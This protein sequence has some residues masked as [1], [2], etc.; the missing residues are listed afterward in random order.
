MKA[1]DIQVYNLVTQQDAATSTT[2]AREATA[3]G[4]S[5]KV[6][7]V[8]T[9]TFLPGTFLSSVFGMSMLNT[10]KWWLYVAI[11]LPLTALV[12]FIWWAW[13]KFPK[14]AALSRHWTGANGSK[15]LRNDTESKV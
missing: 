15:D 14:L 10:A 13:Y 2:I 12:I 11:T 1:N 5:M 9:M 7:A 6:I 3:D 4:A 8:L